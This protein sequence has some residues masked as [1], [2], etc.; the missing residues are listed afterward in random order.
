M[1]NKSRAVA[2]GVMTALACALAPAQPAEPASRAGQNF[3]ND[4]SAAS[5][6]REITGGGGDFDLSWWTVDGGGGTSEGGDFVLRGT[7]GQP[8]AGDL[9]GGEFVLRSGYWQPAPATEGCGDCPT[10]SDSDGDTDAFDLAV[11][12]GAWGPVTPD[13]V[14]LDADD[15]GIIGAFDLAVVLGAWGPCE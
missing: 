6:V 2:F 11:L 1:L 8:D 3:D 15:D 5:A 12:L 14:C 7:I 9:A 4:W 13:S 10:D